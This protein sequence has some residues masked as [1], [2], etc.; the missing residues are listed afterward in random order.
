MPVAQEMMGSEITSAGCSDDMKN[1]TQ[2]TTNWMLLVSSYKMHQ[3]GTVVENSVHTHV[4]IH[5]NEVE[6][7]TTSCAESLRY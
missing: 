6:V 4:Q 7:T 1:K 5:A 2:P 3:K